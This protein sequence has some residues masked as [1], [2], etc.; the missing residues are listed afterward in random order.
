MVTAYEAG[1]RHAAFFEL[2]LREL[3]SLYVQG[4]E[5]LLL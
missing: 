5:A 1:F 3:E 2:R 4:N